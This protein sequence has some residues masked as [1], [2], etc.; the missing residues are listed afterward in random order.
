MRGVAHRVIMRSAAAWQP[1]V[2]LAFWADFAKPPASW[3][4]PVGVHVRSVRQVQSIRQSLTSRNVYR[5]D[6]SKASNRLRRGA[7]RLHNTALSA[8]AMLGLAWSLVMSRIF[9][10]ESY[11]I[12]LFFGHT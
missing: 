9:A 3:T 12:H 11:G 1:M 7:S 4:P 8:R 6:D 2:G 10:N 5:F